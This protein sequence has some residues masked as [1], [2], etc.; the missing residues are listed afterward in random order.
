[1][2]GNDSP[3][4]SFANLAIY[5]S[6]LMTATIGMSSFSITIANN[7]FSSLMTGHVA[8]KSLS[9][10]GFLAAAVAVIETMRAFANLV[11]YKRKE[12]NTTRQVIEKERNPF[13]T[14][15]KKLRPSI[16]RFNIALS[17]LHL[18]K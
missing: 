5:G 12:K 9:S 10:L 1:M 8:E 15:L 7:S 4:I 6:I 13:F 2:F 11:L 17:L 16:S 14:F 3:Q 18:S